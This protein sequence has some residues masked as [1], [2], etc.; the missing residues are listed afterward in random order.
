MAI[1][2]LLLQ[3]FPIDSNL[4]L[5]ESHFDFIAGYSETCPQQEISSKGV[6]RGF[7]GFRVFIAD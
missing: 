3:L 7:N 1:L 5:V 6:D 4:V 2:A